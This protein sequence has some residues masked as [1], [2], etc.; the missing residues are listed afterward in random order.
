MKRVPYERQ[1]LIDIPFQKNVMKK[2]IVQYIFMDTKKLGS[3]L[4]IDRHCAIYTA[5]WLMICA[6]LD[7]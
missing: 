2:S 3:K 4:K 7:V 1:H 5:Y 6:L